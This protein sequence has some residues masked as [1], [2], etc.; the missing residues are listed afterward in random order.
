VFCSTIIPT[1]GRSTLS[2][3]VLSVL[4]Q[5]FLLDN[6][7][8]IVVNDSGQPLP[9]ESWQ[10]SERVHII[11]T[12][13][14]ERSI[15][16]NTGAAV[17][18]GTYLHFLDDDDWLL[19]GALEEFW[20]LAQLNKGAWLYGSTHLVDRKG[21]P[22]IQLHHKING[23]GFIQV[24]AGEWIP[25]Q[26]SIV[27]SESFFEV[28]GFNPLVSGPED[29]DLCRKIALK[30]DFV[31]TDTAIACIAWGQE[32][33]T[34]NPDAH[35]EMSRWAREN[36]LNDQGV[37][38]RMRKSA[39]S[40]YWHGRIMRAYLTSL[41]WNLQRRQIFVAVSRGVFA[42]GGFLL[43]LHHATSR[44]YWQAVKAAYESEVFRQGFL[45]LEQTPDLV[46]GEKSF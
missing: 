28:G 14:R 18:K 4:N 6:F 11:N 32:G 34:T 26:V 13:R 42:L 8:I 22:L 1:V 27:R 16:R 24:M 20:K 45:A 41:I 5:N 7:E 31:Y 3:A 2:R 15:A 9:E 33:S 21:N 10:I 35:P 17:A 30:N 19:P 25:L 29:I 12:N 23:N 40:S 44:S 38:S 46:S 39:T 36:I 43:A 37:F